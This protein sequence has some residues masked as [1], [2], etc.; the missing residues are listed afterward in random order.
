MV[1]ILSVFEE[2]SFKDSFEG[3][4][5]RAVSSESQ[6]EENSRFVRQRCK[7][8]A[9]PPCCLLKKGVRKVL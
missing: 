7:T 9:R 4:E 1:K 5:G 6:T 8:E 2:V 3:R